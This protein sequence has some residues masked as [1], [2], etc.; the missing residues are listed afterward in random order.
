MIHKT[1]P[2]E[3]WRVGRTLPITTTEDFLRS[4][5]AAMR[6]QVPAKS[7]L[8]TRLEQAATAG[9]RPVGSEFN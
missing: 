4:V 2:D 5:G 7:Q 6:C 8:A 9:T 1:G 3:G